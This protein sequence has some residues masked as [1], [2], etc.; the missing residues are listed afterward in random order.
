MNNS[1]LFEEL[2][3]TQTAKDARRAYELIV[4]A[5]RQLVVRL[6]HGRQSYQRRQAE[7]EV[8]LDDM[9]TITG[10]DF[11]SKLFWRIVGMTIDARLR[12]AAVHSQMSSLE[13]SFPQGW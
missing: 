8:F 2:G 13:D 12:R 11:N 7:I 10:L 9:R 6:K 4:E 5:N 1:L 3:R